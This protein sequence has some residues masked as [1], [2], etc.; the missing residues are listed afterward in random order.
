MS[1]EIKLSLR[2]DKYTGAQAEDLS[3]SHTQTIKTEAT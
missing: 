3:L 1:A 2:Q